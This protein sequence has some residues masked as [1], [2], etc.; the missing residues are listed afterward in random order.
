MKKLIQIVFLSAVVWL[1]VVLLIRFP[2]KKVAV[3]E[4]FLNVEW[5]FS[6]Y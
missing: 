6:H 2:A 3:N 1:L 5:K 4:E